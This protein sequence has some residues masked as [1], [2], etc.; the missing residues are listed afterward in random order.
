M[1]P[2][3]IRTP[4]DYVLPRDREPWIPGPPPLA[5]DTPIILPDLPTLA[6]AAEALAR[7]RPPLETKNQ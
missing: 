6:R 2:E 4:R 5:L 3:P 7:H 1:A